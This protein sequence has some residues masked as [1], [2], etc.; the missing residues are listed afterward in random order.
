MFYLIYASTNKTTSPTIHLHAFVDD[1]GLKNHFK[2][3]HI[4]LEHNTVS[5]L[6]RCI[7]DVEIWMKENRLKMNASKMNFIIFFSR[8][9][10]LR[11][12]TTNINICQDRVAK[13]EV[14]KYLGA[15][16]NQFLAYKFHTS[17]NAR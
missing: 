6:E 16:L 8:K 13:S 17:R 11:I 4:I 9:L 15:W 2:I 14:V 7:N 5:D 3:G 12:N 1:Y 10:L